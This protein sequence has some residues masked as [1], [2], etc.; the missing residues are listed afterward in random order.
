MDFERALRRIEEDVHQAKQKQK[1]QV[2]YDYEEVDDVFPSEIGEARNTVNTN[3]LLLAQNREEEEEDDIELDEA[4]IQAYMNLQRAQKLI[5]RQENPDAPTV[6]GSTLRYN[7]PVL[8]VE[9]IKQAHDNISLSEHL[10]WVHTMCLSSLKDLQVMNYEDDMEREMAFYEQA[11]LSAKEACSRLRELGVPTVRP[12]D[13][14]AE[15]IKSDEHMLKVKDKL[16]YSRK[17]LEERETRRRHREQKKLGKQ[18]Q[19][20]RI[21]EKLEE[22][23]NALEAIKYWRKEH[24]GKGKEFDMEK[25][26]AEMKQLKSEQKA[27]NA[28]SKKTL[29]KKER[30][31]KKKGPKR[32]PFDSDGKPYENKKPPKQGGPKGV[33]KQQKQ[34]KKQRPG[35][36]ARAKGRK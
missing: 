1:E 10:P 30:Q 8:K 17:V 16:L 19:V 29:E 6:A 25:L 5:F 27:Q 11:L 21:K 12:D 28:P 34:Q 7:D 13:Y 22:K 4:E 18:M 31:E 24:G 35:K 20:N 3:D 26:D 15:M 32:V 23:K 36:N 2:K 9:Q 14:F 33:Q